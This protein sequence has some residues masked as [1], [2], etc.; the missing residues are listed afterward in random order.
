MMLLKKICGWG[1]VKAGKGKVISN[2]DMGG[3]ICI[4]KSLKNSS[5]LLARISETAEHKKKKKNKKNQED[6]LV[7]MS[8]GTLGALILRDMLT[9]KWVTR[10]GKRVMKEKRR[11]NNMDHMDKKF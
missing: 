1:I 5:K 9:G 10:D 6:V 3:S 2:E 11:Y 4:I 7:G 8:L